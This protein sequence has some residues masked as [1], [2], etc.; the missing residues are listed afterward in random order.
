MEDRNPGQ[1]PEHSPQGTPEQ[2]PSMPSN[3]GTEH[4]VMTSAY[5]DGENYVEEVK[6]YDVPSQPV[7]EFGNPVPCINGQQTADVP[8]VPPQQPPAGGYGA[9]PQPSPQP[10]Y[11]SYQVP[12]AEPSAFSKAWNDIKSTPEAVSSFGFKGLVNC[13]PILNFT[14]W[15]L[16]GKWAKDA[17]DGR[18]E[19]LQKKVVDSDNFVAGFY[20]FLISLILGLV[21]GFVNIVP[22][23]G[24]IAFFVGCFFV[25]TFSMVMFQRYLAFGSFSEAFAIKDIWDKITKRNFG[26]LWVAT[27]VPSLILGLIS[28]AIAFVLMFLFVGI[29]TFGAIASGQSGSVAGVLASLGSMGIGGILCFVV[30]M[31]CDVIAI[32]WGMR[33]CGYWIQKNVPEW[34]SSRAHAERNARIAEE[35]AREQ[36]YRQQAQQQQYAAQQQYYPQPQQQQ[37]AYPQQTVQ[38]MPQQTQ[39]NKPQQQYPPQQ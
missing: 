21:L 12:V 27:F 29:G 28:G 18:I 26:E 32:L 39:G 3:P 15:G 8:P 30:I 20:Y 37:A 1:M 9:V 17:A 11:A 16:G 13:V 25:T 31:F 6:E 2:Q 22:V 35:Q 10:Q 38:S 36:Y 14:V 19:P 4:V 34:N 24:Q 33:G 7:D 23:L 5:Y